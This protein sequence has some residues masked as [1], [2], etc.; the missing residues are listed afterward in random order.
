MMVMMV[1]MVIKVFRVSKVF[2]VFKVFK[3]MQDPPGPPGPPGEPGAIGAGVIPG[4]GSQ[5]G[6]TAVLENGTTT[7]YNT[8]RSYQG[9]VNHLSTSVTPSSAGNRVMVV[10][11]FDLRRVGTQNNN[12]FAYAQLA[13]AN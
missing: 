1:Q 13:T 3:V 4:S 9:F 8:R 7:L 6:D 2:R 11:Q 10:A 12:R 5:T